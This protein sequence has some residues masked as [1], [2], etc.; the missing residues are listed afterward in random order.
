MAT[1]TAG[2]ARTLP[3]EYYTAEEIYGEESEKIFSRRW[4]YA[5][6]ATSLPDPGSFF[7]HE[8]DDESIVILK[9]EQ[10]RVRAFF[11]VCRHRGAR[12]CAESQGRFSRS[13]QC[14]Y[15]SWTYSLD[16]RL[17]GAPNMK[18]VRAFR[19]ED[20]PLRE[21]RVGTWEGNIFLTL[22]ENPGPLEA[23][24]APLVQRFGRWSL[25]GLSVAHRAE[26]EVAANWKLLFQNYSECYHCPNLHPALDR[27]TP[28]RETTNDFSEGPILGGPMNMARAGGSM[29]MTGESC[30]APRQG[31]S[32]SDL[33]KVYYYTIFPN[34]FLTLSPDYVLVHRLQRQRVDLT[35]VICEWLF[36]PETMRQAGFDPKGAI[37]FWDMTNRQDWH[38]C[39]LTQK[40]VSSRAYVPGPYSELESIVAAFDREYLGSMGRVP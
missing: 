27:L 2:N 29:T 25:E 22:A 37:A 7:V 5:G 38:V 21:A 31:V 19:M 13:M 32:E 39:Q 12:F 9:D 30:A 34:M 14:P 4:L 33:G 35:R 16:G 1:R 40:G 26:Y 3:G 15:H 18:E 36:E 11:N 10:S 8:V 23:A 28:Y 17:I 6:R 20:H 24:L